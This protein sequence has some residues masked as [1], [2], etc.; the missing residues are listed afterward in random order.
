MGAEGGEG[1]G[2]NTDLEICGINKPV[3]IGE[4]GDVTGFD[5]RSGCSVE[6]VIMNSSHVVMVSIVYKKSS[7]EWFTK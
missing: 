4:I 7:G 5:Y 3:P 6:I 1:Y 2:W